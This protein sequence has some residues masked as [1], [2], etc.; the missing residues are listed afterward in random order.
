MRP[1]YRFCRDVVRWLA[2]GLWGLRVDGLEKLPRDGAAVV[3]SNHRSLLDPPLLGSVLPR[4][5][6][7]VAKRELFSVPGLSTLIR[8][9]NAIPIER[10]RLSMEK[11]D[12]LAEFLDGGKL[13]LYFPEGTRSRSGELGRAKAGIGV[14]LTKRAVPVVPAF[15]QGTE[16]PVR[17][18][19]RRGRLRIVFGDPQTIPGDAGPEEPRERARWIAEAVLARIRELGE[20]S[21]ENGRAERKL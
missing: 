5:S 8:S 10:G 20:E 17:N 7:F 9:L 14:L 13:L 21:A 12:E 1:W 4:E 6:G 11:M 2:R 16:S 18:L 15:V 19:F 3:A